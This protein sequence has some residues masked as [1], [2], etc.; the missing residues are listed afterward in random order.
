M[1][2]GRWERRGAWQNLGGRR[3]LLALGRGD[4]YRNGGSSARARQRNAKTAQLFCGVMIAELF[5]RH[6]E[7]RRGRKHPKAKHHRQQDGEASLQAVRRQ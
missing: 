6:M 1:I 4:E 3:N 5:R 7:V 2:G